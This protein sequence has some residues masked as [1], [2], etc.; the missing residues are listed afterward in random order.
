MES[1]ETEK[2]NTGFE[3]KVR[4][5]FGIL[6]MALR[7]ILRKH[8]QLYDIIIY[9][10]YFG[11]K[12]VDIAL[13]VNKRDLML[14]ADIIKEIGMDNANIHQMEF[15]NAYKNPVWLTLTTEG[16]SIKENQFLKDLIGIVPMKIYSYNLKQLNQV[17]K[18]QFTRA[19]GQTLGKINGVKFG[20]GV[21]LVPLKEV[22]YFEEFLEFWGLKYE[23]KEWNVF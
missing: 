16:F 2:G 5:N 8:P 3:P 6:K 17:R 10:S 1:C 13:I 9:G 4:S 20:I 23:A 12:G 14:Q 11:G 19:L 22:S 21:V 7:N 15:N 18:V